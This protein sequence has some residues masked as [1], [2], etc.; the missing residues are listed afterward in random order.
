VRDVA[1]SRI[2]F[3]GGGTGGHLYPA[4]NIADAVRRL[5]PTTS[6]FFVGSRRGIEARVLPGTGYEHRLLPLEPIQRSRPWRNWRLAVTTPAVV[7]GISTVFRTFR[8]ELVVGTGGYVSGAALAWARLKRVPMALQEQNAEPGFV[9][10][11]MAR[12]AT[13]IHLGYPE[14]RSRLEFGP[15]TRVFD[16]GNPVAPVVSGEEL[17][18]AFD[19][20]A[21]RVL[22]VVGGSQG[23][24]AI[25]ERLLADLE[26]ADTEGW[27]DDLTVVW[28]AG[29]DHADSVARRVERLTCS[30]RIRVTPFIT[31]LGRQLE[32]V[33]LALSRAG[34]M[35]VAEFAVAGCPAVL[36][37]LPTAAA[38]H[39]SINARALADA[40]AALARTEGDLE[41]GELWSACRDLL[42][43][44]E[45]LSSMSKAARGRGR[46]EA[47]NEIARALLDLARGASM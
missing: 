33:T 16:S 7:G 15:G 35:L 45:R 24:R 18:G 32:R 14:A 30:D 2:L 20:P 31:D 43:D 11:V 37:P 46:P 13:Q 36:V 26:S 12:H 25:N 38:D 42:N 5:D 47:A 17:Q 27:P 19:W 4:L 44:S 23:A 40:G 28:V 6:C 21:G 10:R 41:P 39:Q 1:G 22:L 29:R 34:A 3:A 8:P 9:T